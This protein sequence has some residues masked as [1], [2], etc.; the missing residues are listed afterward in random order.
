[1]I[2][3]S[4]NQVLRIVKAAAKIGEFQYQGENGEQHKK[5]RWGYVEQHTDEVAWIFFGEFNGFSRLGLELV[6]QLGVL[7]GG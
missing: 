5:Y 7:L 4:E 3:D 6:A 1:M 2:V